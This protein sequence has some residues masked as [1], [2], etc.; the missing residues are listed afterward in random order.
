MTI[1]NFVLIGYY[2]YDFSAATKEA[3]P[4]PHWVWLVASVNIFTAY[5]LGNKFLFLFNYF[6]REV[7]K[8]V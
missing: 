7:I 5:T 1:F 2:D 8:V 4:V 6:Y 3:N